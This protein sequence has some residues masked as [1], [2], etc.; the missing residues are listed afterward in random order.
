MDVD[1]F[2][3]EEEVCRHYYDKYWKKRSCYQ[4]S[5]KGSIIKDR[6]V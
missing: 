6:E 2:E 4:N 5:N 3:H 1:T